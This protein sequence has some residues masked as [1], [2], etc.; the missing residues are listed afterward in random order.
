MRREMDV[1]FIS[2]FTLLSRVVQKEEEELFG[3]SGS[4]VK[5][6]SVVACH[7]THPMII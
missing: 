4:S 6:A 3:S 1:S 7:I 5:R 2:I